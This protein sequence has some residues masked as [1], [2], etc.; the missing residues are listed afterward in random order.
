MSRPREK[1]AEIVDRTLPAMAK[2]AGARATSVFRIWKAPALTAH[3]I[4]TFRPSNGPISPG[5]SPAS[6]A[7][8]HQSHAFRR[9]KKSAKIDS[10]GR[11]YGHTGRAGAL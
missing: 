4:E 10:L 9:R 2:T 11:R 3:R 6:P 5:D 7:L 8:R 1:V